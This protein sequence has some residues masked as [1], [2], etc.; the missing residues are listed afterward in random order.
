MSYLLIFATGAKRTES[1]MQDRP[2]YRDY[3]QRVALFVP[4]PPKTAT[5]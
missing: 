2:G 5:D 1:R 4:R 3:Q